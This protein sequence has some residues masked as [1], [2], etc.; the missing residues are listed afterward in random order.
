MLCAWTRLL[1]GAPDRPPQ[2]APLQEIDWTLTGRL[3]DSIVQQLTVVWEDL[4]GVTLGRGEIETH[5]T[6]ARSHR[7]ASRRSW[8]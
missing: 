2:R 3:F 5:T 8:S 4:A 1:G 7:S 6:P